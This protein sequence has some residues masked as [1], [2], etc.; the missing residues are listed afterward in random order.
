MILLLII[1]KIIPDIFIQHSIILNFSIFNLIKILVIIPAILREKNFKSAN[2]LL[3]KKPSTR[4]VGPTEDNKIYRIKN[5][6]LF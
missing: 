5:F 3:K 4:V 2:L 1:K 6:H